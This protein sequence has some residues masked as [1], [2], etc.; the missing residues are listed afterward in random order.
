[1]TTSITTMIEG[2]STNPPAAENSETTA[3]DGRFGSRYPK[4]ARKRIK[5]EGLFL[6][7]VP[8]LGA[9][10]VGILLRNEFAG[11]DT[12]KAIL[13]CA[14]GGITGSWMYSVR[15]YVHAVIR[16][17]WRSDEVVE[18]LTTPFT[19]IFLAVSA[20]TLIKTGMLGV[21]FSSESNTDPDLYGYAIGFLVGLFSEDV[22]GKL[23]GV[24]KTF[25]GKPA[26][27]GAGKKSARA[28]H[29]STNAEDK[30][31]VSS[32]R[33]TRRARGAHHFAAVAHG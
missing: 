29:K 24:V 15:V 9:L 7:G 27:D 25:F 22:M 20:Y 5:L 21:T 31:S 33:T 14:L 8:L 26:D 2:F 1:M 6:A 12:L 30:A 18:R 3:R 19:G 10:L 11:R 13:I 32:F 16:G 17:N 4:D 28:A 23:T